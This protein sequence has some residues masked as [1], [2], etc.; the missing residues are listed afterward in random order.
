MKL[1]DGRSDEWLVDSGGDLGGRELMRRFKVSLA[2]HQAALIAHQ[3]TTNHL[4]KRI[5]TLTTWI[6]WLT[7]VLIIFG[8]LQLGF[9]IWK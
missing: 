4:T 8:A 7:V 2:E 9:M 3:E 6:V 5:E 1:F